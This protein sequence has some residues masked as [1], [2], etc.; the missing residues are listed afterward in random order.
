M[1]EPSQTTTASWHAVF[2]P[3]AGGF[4]GPRSNDAEVIRRAW[5][6]INHPENRIYLSRLF[7]QT[8]MA[9]RDWWNK[10]DTDTELRF[11][12]YLDTTAIGSMGVHHID[13]IHG[14]ATT[15]TVI[16]DPKHR[17]QGVA[18]KAKIVLLEYLFNTLNLRRVY[19]RRIGYNGGSGRYSDKCGYVEIARIPGHFRFGTTFEDEVVMM[20]ERETWFPCFAAYQAKHQTAHTRQELVQLHRQQLDKQ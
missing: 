19:S 3:F 18:T 11:V 12:I 1:Q 9:Q 15:G 7:P 13:F 10:P 14:H 4:L 20:C 16:W 8:E 2:I 6:G 17:N 5:I